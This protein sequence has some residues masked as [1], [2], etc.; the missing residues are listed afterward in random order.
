M[1][2]T[3]VH[4]ANVRPELKLQYNFDDCRHD[5]WQTHFFSRRRAFYFFSFSLHSSF[6]PHKR[7]FRI[8]ITRKTFLSNFFLLL[9]LL[10]YCRVHILW[11]KQTGAVFTFFL[12]LLSLSEVGGVCSI[13][14]Q[15]PLRFTS[16]REKKILLNELWTVANSFLF[17]LVFPSTP[18]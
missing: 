4:K 6:L 3:R 12:S 10:V 15:F 13:F 1:L 18:A 17:V 2:K 8:Q 14:R 9:L 16:C 7:K 11:I 5:K